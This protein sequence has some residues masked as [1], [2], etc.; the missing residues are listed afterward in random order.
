MFNPS[1]SIRV[2]CEIYLHEHFMILWVSDR[3]FEYHTSNTSDTFNITM[4][5]LIVN[6]WFE[7][8]HLLCVYGN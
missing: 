8:Y 6:V 3:I 1:L 5:I 7:N 2:L 4:N